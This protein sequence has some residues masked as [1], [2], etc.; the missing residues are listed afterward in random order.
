MINRPDDRIGIPHFTCPPEKI[1]AIV[2]TDA[3]DRNTAF[4]PIDEDSRAIANHLIDFLDLEVR[5]GR[6]PPELLPL[7]SGVGNIANAVLAG[8]GQ[9]H[10][11]GLTAYTEVLQDGMLDLLESGTPAQALE[12]GA[13]VA[14]ELRNRLRRAVEQ[15][16]FEEAAKLRDQLKVME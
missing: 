4:K 8:L 10:H 13:S 15:E 16:Q 3:P 12:E 6:M 1:V 14:T 11:R 9:T 2:E 7:Q 5:V